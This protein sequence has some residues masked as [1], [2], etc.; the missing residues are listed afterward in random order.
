MTH[1]ASFHRPPGLPRGTR[2]PTPADP[3]ELVSRGRSDAGRADLGVGAPSQFR[4]RIW[5]VD[6]RT[7]SSGIPGR[8]AVKPCLQ[9]EPVYGKPPVESF[10]AQTVVTALP[11]VLRTRG[12]SGVLH[13]CDVYFGTTLSGVLGVSRNRK[14]LSICRSRPPSRSRSEVSTANT[15]ETCTPFGAAHK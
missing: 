15:N 9:K 3:S 4:H 13:G 6:R 5:H 7:P 12:N 10:V 2:P 11:A 1:D 8:M 14:L